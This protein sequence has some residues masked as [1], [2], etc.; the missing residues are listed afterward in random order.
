MPSADKSLI[1]WSRNAVLTRPRCGDR[2]CARAVSFVVGKPT[3]K[4]TS[5]T[6][7]RAASRSW[8][9]SVEQRSRIDCRVWIAVAGGASDTG[10]GLPRTGVRIGVDVHRGTPNR[11]PVNAPAWPRIVAGASDGYELRTDRGCLGD[12]DPGLGAPEIAAIV[13]VVGNDDVEDFEQVGHGPGM[14]YQDIHGGHQRPDTRVR[15]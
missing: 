2:G 14:G 1:S 3:G 15:R 10:V 11:L 4:S 12:V 5:T 9:G 13:R 7:A 8:R 6:S